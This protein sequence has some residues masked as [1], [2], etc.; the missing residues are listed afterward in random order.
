MA[1][2]D[3][4]P[5]VLNTLAL[6]TEADDQEQQP[7]PTPEQDPGVSVSATS[8]AAAENV[9]GS[10]ACS[11]CSVNFPTIQ[12]QKSHVRSDFHHYNLKQKLRGLSP[13]SELEFEKL[14]ESKQEGFTDSQGYNLALT[15]PRPG[16]ESF[17]LRLIRYR[18]RRRV[19]PERHNAHCAF[20]EAGD[21][22]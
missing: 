15:F 8:D 14:I 9:V 6:K 18:G 19:L 2:Y 17:G 3:L 22:G 21:S 7:Q 12:E 16:R 1:V 11:L 5:E 10:R 4:P 13:V 20:E